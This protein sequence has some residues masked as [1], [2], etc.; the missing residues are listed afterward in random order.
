MTPP[1]DAVIWNGVTY[2]ILVPAA[3]TEGRLGIFESEDHPG[4]GPPRHIHNDADETFV[5]LEGEVEFLLNGVARHCSPRDTVFVPRGTEHT[6]C[7]R[8]TAPARML[9]VMTPGGFEGFFRDMA[10][11]AYRIPQ[12][13]PRIAAIAA[14]YQLEFTGPPLT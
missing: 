6:F 4:Y 14:T 8:G 1:A 12:D 10:Q 5:V 7:V 11:G 9:T 13:M 3:A 2:R